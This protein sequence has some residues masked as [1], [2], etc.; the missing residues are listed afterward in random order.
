LHLIGE[1]KEHVPFTIFS[2]C[3]GLTLVGILTYLAVLSNADG[4]V[5]ASRDLFHVF[6]PVHLLLSA[7]ATTAM[8]RKHE[9]KVLKAV[10]VGLVGSLG[11]CGISDMCIPFLGGSLLGIEMQLHMCILIH[12]SVVVP[13]IL[14]GILCGLG[15]AETIEKST[16]YSHAGHVLVSSMASILYLVSYGLTEW[17]HVIGAVF[18]ITVLAVMV[19]CCISDVVFPLLMVSSK[20]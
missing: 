5:D 14:L 11:I 19:P 18:I 10:V 8:F 9:K 3:M 20:E 7:T 2:A 6:H 4:F 16:V 17:V 13:F 12:P 1:L 15:A